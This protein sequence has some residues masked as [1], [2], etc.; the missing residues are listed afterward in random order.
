MRLVPVV[1]PAVLSL[2][3]LAGCGDEQ[4]KEKP[5]PSPTR[6]TAATDPDS[7]ACGRLLP[8]AAVEEL[9]G[10]PAS[11]VATMLGELDA[12][13]WDLDPGEW[14]QVVDVASP[15]WAAVLPESLAQAKASGDFDAK[16]L[17]T[18]EAG[19][20]PVRAGRKLTPQQACALFTTYAREIVG[21]VDSEAVVQFLPNQT[22]PQAVSA[23]RCTRGRY[24]AVQLVDADLLGANEEAAR[25]L[26][27]LSSIR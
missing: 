15:Q 11:P 7:L 1:L 2:L 5:T 10:M 16:T 18:L 17:A 23:Q 13:R 6:T 4:P 19:L 22:V 25:V 27:A 21:A 14:I 3:L 24:T 20:A 8:A 26:N 9:A 12:C